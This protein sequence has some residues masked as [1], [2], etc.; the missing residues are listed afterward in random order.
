M[1]E[2]TKSAISYSW[3]MSLFGAQQVAKFVSP[4]NLCDPARNVNAG[5]Y[6]I[7]Q[8]LETELNR[9]DLLFGAFLF[10]NDAQ[11]A[12]VDFTLDSLTLRVFAPNYLLRLTEDISI[13]FKETRR[14]FSS[15]ESARIGW[16]ELKNNLEVFSTG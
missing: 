13:Q 6:S 4:A 9:N 11:R 2:L 12:L 8:A 5:F 3:A 16:D 7:T 10:G 1:L 15:L 14:V